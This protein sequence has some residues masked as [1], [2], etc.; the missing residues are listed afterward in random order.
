MSSIKAL[1]AKV[2]A[3]YVENRVNSWVNKPVKTQ[4]RVFKALID[5]AK[6][7]AFGTVHNFSEIKSYE[8]FQNQV[9]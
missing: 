2:F 4:E 1:L 7:T 5:Q 8:D 6:N 3:K 9:P